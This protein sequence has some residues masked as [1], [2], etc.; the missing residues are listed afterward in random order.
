M[1]DAAATSAAPLR[2]SG[3]LADGFAIEPGSGLIGA[4]FPVALPYGGRWQAILNVDG[5]LRRV[6]EGYVQQA[7]GLG[8]SFDSEPNALERQRCR[9]PEAQ[10]T[11]AGASEQ[12]LLRCSAS[13]SGPRDVELS[14][15]GS[16]DEAG[17]GHVNLTVRDYSDAPAPTTRPLEGP[18]A[19]ATDVELAPEWT[20]YGDER[21]VRVVNGSAVIYGPDVDP[22][23]GY[24]VMVQVTGDL[25]S[26]MLGYEKQFT[27]AHF[28]SRGF[29]GDRDKPILLTSTAGG[30]DL[31]AVG[32][33]GEPS[34]VLITR[35]NDP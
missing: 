30:G 14:I 32:V 21:S 7:E 33:A 25:T 20:P 28:T 13:G 27:G 11:G 10:D 15:A 31:I 17:D 23:Y 16:V 4:V 12:F 35:N 34:F 24:T 18:V 8:Y 3:P 22:V 19:P 29:T 6:F 9:G 26:V 2:T 1:D 5:D